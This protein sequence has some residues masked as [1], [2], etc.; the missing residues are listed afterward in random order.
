M[1][2]FGF[3]GNRIRAVRPERVF[4]PGNDL[5]ARWT[6]NWF[7]TRSRKI[8]RGRFLYGYSWRVNIGTVKNSTVYT[9]CAHAHIY[10]LNI[11]TNNIIT[12]GLIRMPTV[13]RVGVRE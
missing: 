3:N 9:V 10:T 1:C 5:R 11:Y 4:L 13:V 6:R 8:L 2:N 7:L 12:P